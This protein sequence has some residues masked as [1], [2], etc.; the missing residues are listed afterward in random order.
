MR[1]FIFSLVALCS[2]LFFASANAQPIEEGKNYISLRSPVATQEPS[3]IE[4]V[5]LFW[6]GCPHCY[7]LEPTLAA[8]EKKLPEDVNFIRVPAMF[9]GIWNL[10][11]QLY[12][13]LEAIGA[14]EQL[15]NLIFDVIQN[16]KQRLATPAEIT[17]FV[18]Q[19]GIDKESFEKAWDSF[20]VKSQ[21]QKAKRLAISYQVSG[22][23][24]LVV[25]GKYSFDIGSAGGLK[26]TTAV[27]DYLIAQ[28]RKN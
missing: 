5:A 23:P 9:G 4:V 24:A 12:Y 13:T 7:Q 14:T 27:A 18:V 20:A 21:L 28:E 15:H 19:Q 11:A 26:E 10:H 8:W 2:A 16:N 25:N 6:Y 22:V 1:N 17:K 3:K